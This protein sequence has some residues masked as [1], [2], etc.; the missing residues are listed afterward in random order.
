VGLAGFLFLVT[1]VL[2]YTSVA[3]EVKKLSSDSGKMRA[4]VIAIDAL[5]VFGDLERPEVVFF[6]DLHTDALEKKG[7]TCT[8]CHLSQVGGT[9]Q[10]EVDRL[11]PK[12]K[13]LNDT[14]RQGVMEIY[15]T[16]CLACHQEASAAG[17]NAGP[18]E[19]CGDC[20][21]DKPRAISSRQPMGFDKSLH[22]SHSK[23]NRNKDT[24][25][26]D[27]GLCHHEYNEEAKK[28]FWAKGKE[29]SCRYCHMEVKEENRI[30]MRLASHLSCINCHRKTLAESKDA[31]PIK[32]GGCHDLKNQQMIAKV[33]DVPRIKRNQPDIILMQ[34]EK[35]EEGK[36]KKLAFKMNPVPFDHK[37]HEGYNDTCQVCHHVRLDSCSKKCHTLT[38]SKESKD[39]KLE[40]AMHQ[41][42]AKMSCLGCH[43][44]SQADKNCA[45]CHTFIEKGGKKTESFCLVCHMKPIQEDP[46]FALKPQVI[47]S[48]LLQLK[49][50]ITETY[51]DEEIPEKVV[52]K[53]LVD[54]YDPVELPHRKIVHTLVENIKDNKLAKY[55]HS[56]KGTVCQA[57]HHNSPVAKK[58]PRC[59]SCHGK[60][61][62]DKNLLRPGMKAAYH[63]QCMGCHKEMGMDKPKAV[64]CTDCHKER[65]K[66]E[67]S[68]Y[69]RPL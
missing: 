62:D 26:G 58:P 14:T 21:R 4:D 18:V 34:A 52:I 51:K 69:G 20:H 32:C 61:F 37:A 64:G 9:S 3:Q 29:G 63:Q 67:K 59:G 31:G 1:M 13:R 42:E 22:F 68:F 2:I 43:G 15:H 35:Q 41:M 24:N 47:A 48:R 27:C 12:F 65:R 39:V 16:N 56:E 60:P 40:R 17:E 19:V 46:E 7:K 45:G 66:P 49:K 28:L 57:C 50:A 5:T 54:K 38:G 10:S 6:H 8:T 11:S 23:A 53:G 30:S 55:F 25:E 33:P 36:Q 44:V